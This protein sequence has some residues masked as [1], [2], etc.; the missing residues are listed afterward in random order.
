MRK[1]L[2]V[3]FVAILAV[4][5]AQVWAAPIETGSISELTD[6][7]KAA[8]LRDS[9]VT[10][11]S[12]FDRTG[13]NDDGFSG[14]Y[15]YIRKE[16][17]NFVIFDAEGPGCLYRLWS[18][19]AG[20]GWVKFYFDGED[21][22][23]IQFDHFEDM[24]TNVKYP[25]IPPFSQHFLGGWS[26]YIPLPFSK[27]LKIV[28]QGPVRF[29]QMDWR[30]FPS[31][32]GVVT[33]DPN[34]TE[35]QRVQLAQ[36]K[37]IWLKPGVEPMAFSADSIDENKQ[38][39]VAPGQTAQLAGI[40]GAGL[41][42]CIRIKAQ[43]QDT[44]FLRRSL[45]LVNVDGDHSPNVYSP[46][47][48]FFLDPFGGENA[49]SL[50]AGKVNDQYYSYWVMPYAKGASVGVKNESVS[51][52]ELTCEIVYEPVKKLPEGMGRFFA[53]WHRQ[54][55][56]INGKLFPILNAEGHGQWC[57]VSHA[58]Q[59]GG[60]GLGFLEGDE[61]AWLDG[62][63]N[64]SYNGTGT[65]DYFNGGWYFGA[66]G[67]A[68]F[69]GCGVLEGG[70][71]CHAY[72]I[73]LTDLVPFQKTAVIGIEHGHANSVPADYAGVTFWYAAPGT[74]HDFAP[75][76]V[77]DRIDRPSPARS[78]IEAES[79]FD[80]KAGG[81]IVTDLNQPFFLS[82]GKG[83]SSGSKAGGSFTLK[84]DAPIQDD[85][86]LALFL[87]RGPNRGVAEVSVDGQV[88]GSVDTYRPEV[89]G[90]VK[91]IVGPTGNLAKGPHSLTIK[92]TGKNATASGSEVVL[93]YLRLRSAL[94]Y[95]GE[96]MEIANKNNGDAAKQDLGQEF[97]EGAHMFFQ[98]RDVGS[99]LDLRFSVQKSGN[100]SLSMWLTKAGDY[101]IVQVKMDGKPI[102][103]P[104]DG[105]ND[106]VTREQVNFG[107][108]T[109]TRGDHTVSLE[110][111]GKNP[112]SIGYFAG[113][114]VM[115]LR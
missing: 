17:D 82:G 74:K 105:Y 4:I 64:T 99:R 98:G 103:Q 18:A 21:T 10:Q 45:L 111:T 55:P 30:K 67:S 48:D 1:L 27:S 50:I 59:G 114:D 69:Y 81:K 32:D 97:S 113:L 15:S 23:S 96:S 75:T 88:V 51:P 29:L 90:A 2:V 106:G 86:Q 73:Q 57:G 46:L 77:V 38:V 33:F 87:L 52:L 9:V 66:T 93:D 26:S 13:G 61:M 94:A 40:S 60:Q 12:S 31:G 63:D 62:R 37:R 109:L 41:I 83:V 44:K 110:L 11:V 58:M 70:G 24:F 80:A 56:T 84:F 115:T 71:K 36:I 68:P 22:P 39:T 25:F 14:T 7:V 89:A 65:E 72:R 108:V 34:F 107:Q 53:W 47:G 76:D 28:A 43:C 49:Q 8:Y 95:E 100:Y 19:N 112:K 54:N 102:G 3:V 5:A 104:F 16:G 91:S 42:R 20:P 6:V 92:S 79:I 78:V 85:Y 101:G 35:Q